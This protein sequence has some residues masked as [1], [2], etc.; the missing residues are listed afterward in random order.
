V[1]CVMLRVMQWMELKKVECNKKY[2]SFR[3]LFSIFI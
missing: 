3:E 1:L 2:L